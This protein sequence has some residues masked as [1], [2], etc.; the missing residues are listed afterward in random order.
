MLRKLSTFKVSLFLG[1]GFGQVQEHL[2]KGEQHS[3]SKLLQH[4]TGAENFGDHDI[5]ASPVFRALG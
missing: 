5:H 3:A 4:L 2:E 1:D